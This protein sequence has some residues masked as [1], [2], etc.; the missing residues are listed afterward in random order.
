MMQFIPT[1]IDGLLQIQPQVHRDHRGFFL[2]SYSAEQF[3]K[4][5]IT[6]RFVQ[7]NHSCSM[8]TGVL[9]GLHFQKPPF[10]QTKLIRVT[11]GRIFDVAVDLRTKS[12]TFGRWFGLELSADN[13]TMLLIPAGFAHGFCTLENE[14]HVEYKV[15]TPYAPQYDS[16]IIWNDPE[17]AVSWPVA[18]PILSAKD[19]KL[20]RLHETPSPF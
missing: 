1:G 7:D 20:P 9:R 10:A 6:C 11:R 13:F 12:P 8:E 4:A 5:G 16:G 2:E 3:D 18:A 15:D 17:I 19:A 14:T